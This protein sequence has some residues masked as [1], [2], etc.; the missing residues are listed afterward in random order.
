[1]QFKN[2]LLHIVEEEVVSKAAAYEKMG[3]EQ[4]QIEFK[5]EIADLIKKYTI[6]NGVSLRKLY[7]NIVDYYGTD[8]IDFS[9]RTFE[10]LA[11][12]DKWYSGLSHRQ[13]KIARL[14]VLLIFRDL[15]QIKLSEKLKIRVVGE[16][17]NRPS[18]KTF[19]GVVK[20]EIEK[21]FSIFV[22]WPVMQSLDLNLTHIDALFEVVHKPKNGFNP[23]QQGWVKT[24]R[25]YDVSFGKV[26]N[27]L[28]SVFDKPFSLSVEI[29]LPLP[30]EMPLAEKLALHLTT[31]R[32]P[33]VDGVKLGWYS[34][35]ITNIVTTK[36]LT[37]LS[38]KVLPIM[39]EELT[40]VKVEEVNGLN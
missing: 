17:V 28:V 2:K 14:K 33:L 39:G 37:N 35:E 22:L 13:P 11:N 40:R 23:S 19:Y 8:N 26:I 12:C 29:Y 5:F 20:D 27:P 36:L 6:D 21:D 10:G 16:K 4:P 7:D 31:S 9:L 25:V 1:M 18:L 24:P 15:L 34:R 30:D 38:I 32:T 3:K